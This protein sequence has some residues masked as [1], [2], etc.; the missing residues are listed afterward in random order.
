LDYDDRRILAMTMLMHIHGPFERVPASIKRQSTVS[1]ETAE[2]HLAAAKRFC[3]GALMV[4]AAFGAL[5]AVIALKAAIY[6][7]RFH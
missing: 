3:I 5:A 2:N 1:A 7:W 6:Y 4:L